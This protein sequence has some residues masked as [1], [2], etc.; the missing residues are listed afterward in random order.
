M[1]SERYRINETF[2][3]AAEKKFINFY[4]AGANSSGESHPVSRDPEAK[5]PG[6]AVPERV[7]HTTAAGI[8]SSYSHVLEQLD[9]RSASTL[10]KIILLS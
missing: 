6:A 2:N 3:I 1:N 7:L 9:G 10:Q 5:E 8:H 4:V